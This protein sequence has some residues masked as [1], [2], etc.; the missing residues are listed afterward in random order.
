MQL[1]NC[2]WALLTM[3]NTFEICSDQT[4]LFIYIY[5]HTDRAMITMILLYTVKGISKVIISTYI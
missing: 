1:S 2:K 5:G 3:P 4:V